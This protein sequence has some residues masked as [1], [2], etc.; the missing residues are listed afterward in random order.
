VT[1]VLFRLT[2]VELK[3]FSREPLAVLFAFAL[4][5]IVL[6]VLTGL[7]GDYPNRTS[8]SSRRRITT[9]QAIWRW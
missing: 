7:Y 6:A 3:L 1:T 2:W 8:T 9:S 5:L 4:P